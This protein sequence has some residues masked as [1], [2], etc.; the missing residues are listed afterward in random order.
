[1]WTALERG[2]F[3]GLVLMALVFTASAAEDGCEKFAW[4]LAKERGWFAAS[5]L[6][7]IRAGEALD[8]IPS[9]AFT[10]RLEPASEASF[11]LPPERKPKSDAWFG[12]MMRLPPP[13]AGLYQVTL[14]QDAWIDIVQDGRYARSVGSTGR[15]DCPGLR[16]SVRLELGAT[17]FVLQ[18]Q[19]RAYCRNPDG[20]QPSTVTGVAQCA[21]QT[22]NKLPASCRD[23]FPA[24]GRAESSTRR[25]DRRCTTSY[26]L[27]MTHDIHPFHHSRDRLRFPLWN[28]PTIL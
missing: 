1:M 19:R 17:P 11:A 21:T 27:L 15:G 3:I 5:D 7:S 8:A 13:R 4:S 9:G 25:A 2:G 18:S 16:K 26:L 20:Y 12:G 24:S 28:S 14:S 22:R 23:S 6:P 10:I